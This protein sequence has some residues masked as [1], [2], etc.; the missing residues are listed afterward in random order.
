LYS[1]SDVEVGSKTH[2]FVENL[3]IVNSIHVILNICIGVYAIGPRVR[4]SL[5]L[6]VYGMQLWTNMTA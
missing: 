1:V 6:S 2:V 5:F 4:Y 3:K